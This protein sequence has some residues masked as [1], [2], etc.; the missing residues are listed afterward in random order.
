MTLIRYVYFLSKLQ[1]ES[2]DEGVY[3]CAYVWVRKAQ[4]SD[5]VIYS[6][7]YRSLEDKNTP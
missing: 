5:A 3:M 7:G 6:E 4:E 2:A 1:E